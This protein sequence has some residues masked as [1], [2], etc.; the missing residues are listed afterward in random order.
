MKSFKT[1]LLKSKISSL[2]IL[3]TCTI[4]SCDQNMD[5]K[6]TMKIAE[7]TNDK[8]FSKAKEKDAEYL[9]NAAEINIEE[10]KLGQL[11]QKKSSTPEVIELAKMM[12]TSHMKA[13]EKLQVLAS[14]KKI[15]IPIELTHD[16]E[17]AYYQ[18][19]EI[20]GS[21]FDYEY[22]DRVAE[23]HKNAI[24]QFLGATTTTNDNE[25]RS[26]AGSFVIV[27]QKHFDASIACKKK[28]EERKSIGS[29]VN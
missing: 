19:Q 7:D 9:M 10:I 14:K 13:L 28:C 8:K 29:K 6:D 23:V 4:L 5:S 16:S 1:T 15:A 17:K 25:I 26:W 11:A 12:E 21:D 20:A 3:A 27:L 2:V 22:C 24:K 18:L